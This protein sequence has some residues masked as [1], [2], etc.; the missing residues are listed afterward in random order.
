APDATST[1]ASPGPTAIA[2][3]PTVPRR[4]P[5][6]VANVTVPGASGLMNPV[7]VIETS[8]RAGS[9]WRNRFKNQDGNSRCERYTLVTTAVQDDD[10]S[11]Q[12]ARTSQL[13]STP[14]G[15]SMGMACAAAANAGGIVPC[16]GSSSRNEAHHPPCASSAV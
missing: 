2:L 4:R 14:N 13:W 10:G 12:S 7:I 11:R 3:P 1:R 15:S 5:L 16:N 8:S 6:P 9:T